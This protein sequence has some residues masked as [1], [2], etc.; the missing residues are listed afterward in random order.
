MTAQIIDFPIRAMFG[1]LSGAHEGA[2][3]VVIPLDTAPMALQDRFPQNDAGDECD[4]G[5]NGDDA[6]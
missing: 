3:G 6:A 1:G 4:C 5:C 2:M